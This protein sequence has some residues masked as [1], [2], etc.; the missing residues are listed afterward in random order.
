MHLLALSQGAHGVRM[1][2]YDNNA[3]VH[4]HE[5]SVFT[6]IFFMFAMPILCSQVSS[7]SPRTG[8]TP[9]LKRKVKTK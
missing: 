4:L 5:E 1:I 2:V 6:S 3:I 8:T 9:S 7:L